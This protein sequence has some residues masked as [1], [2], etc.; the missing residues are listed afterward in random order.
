MCVSHRQ[1]YR[2][3]SSGVVH[4]DMAHLILDSRVYDLKRGSLG[5]VLH[6]KA[7]AHRLLSTPGRSMGP[8]DIGA[9]YAVHILGP[10][11]WPACRP[12]LG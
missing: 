10:D 12:V 3:K 4:H 1:C 2:D 9:G 11:V 7:L 8:F 6:V 5:N